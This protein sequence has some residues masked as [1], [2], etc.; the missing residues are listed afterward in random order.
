MDLDEYF[1]RKFSSKAKLCRS[2]GIDSS[3]LFK[4]IN[5][6]RMPRL[7]IALKIVKASRGRIV[8]ETLVPKAYLPLKLDRQVAQIKKVVD[9][10]LL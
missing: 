4:Y 10:D 5:K 1:R 2:V 7:D 9:S 3:S 8:I 6:S